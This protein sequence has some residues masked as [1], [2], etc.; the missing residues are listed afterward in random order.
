MIKILCLRH[1]TGLVA[2]LIS[3]GTKKIGQKTEDTPSHVVILFFNHL[4]MQSTGAKGVHITK[5]SSLKEHYEVINAF[6]YKNIKEFM[7]AVEVFLE[8][9]YKIIDMKYDFLGTFFLGVRFF[10]HKFFGRIMPSLNKWQ[11]NRQIFCV[12]VANYITGKNYSNLSPNDL[13]Y[14]LSNRSDF[15]IIEMD[16]S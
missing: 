11:K 6:K 3:F 10:L 14:R 5:L 2:R 1:K 13:M 15:E 4:V 8:A 16:W 9:Q 12:E 7:E